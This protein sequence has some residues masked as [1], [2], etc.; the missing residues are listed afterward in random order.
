MNAVRIEGL[1]ESFVVCLQIQ[2][3]NK[4]NAT[5]L[6]DNMALVYCPLFFITW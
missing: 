6:D 5:L 2:A 3:G 1:H 4:E